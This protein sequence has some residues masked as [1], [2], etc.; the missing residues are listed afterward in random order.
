MSIENDKKLTPFERAR[1]NVNKTAQNFNFYNSVE[2]LAFAIETLN[3]FEEGSEDY[4]EE[5]DTMCR[6][7]IKELS[8]VMMKEGDKWN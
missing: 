1:R 5:L 3:K 8:E 6:N 4:S 2:M 7:I